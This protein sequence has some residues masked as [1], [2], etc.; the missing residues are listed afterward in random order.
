M[1]LPTALPVEFSCCSQL[2]WEQSGLEQANNKW[3]AWLSQLWLKLKQ[4]S[5]YW[6]LEGE[7]WEKGE[8]WWWSQPGSPRDIYPVSRVTGTARSDSQWG[9][10]SRGLC[11]WEIERDKA[12]A[13]HP[14][15]AWL[16]GNQSWPVLMPSPLTGKQLNF[17]SN[18]LQPFRCTQLK[19]LMNL[20]YYV[21]LSITELWSL[22]KVSLAG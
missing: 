2:V 3:Q 22:F 5:S 18:K 9:C 6:Q 11:L 4:H 16:Q 12:V 19:T 10:G 21:A 15:C 8:L 17:I 1:L 20:R 7:K 14:H 13:R